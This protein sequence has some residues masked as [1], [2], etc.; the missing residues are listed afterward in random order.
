MNERMQRRDFARAAAAGLGALTM[1]RGVWAQQGSGRAVSLFDGNTLN[2][3]TKM[4]NKPKNWI[5]RAIARGEI[6]LQIEERS[7]LVRR[8]RRN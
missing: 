5:N 6:S 7:D 8:H 1:P 2:G 4:Q 3:W